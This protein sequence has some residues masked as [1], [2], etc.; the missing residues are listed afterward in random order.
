MNLGVHCVPSTAQWQKQGETVP[1]LPAGLGVTGGFNRDL[2]SWLVQ[3]HGCVVLLCHNV[4]Q[5]RENP[6]WSA[7]L[8][9]L[10]SQE[11]DQ[12]SGGFK[13]GGT[14]SSRLG[15]LTGTGLETR[16]HLYFL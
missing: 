3:S 9:A 14:A 1:L 2:E 5:I 12:Q 6:L 4:P 10:L 8:S 13:V 16:R 15:V 7:V 11:N